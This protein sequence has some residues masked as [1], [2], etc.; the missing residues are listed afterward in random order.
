MLSQ[1]LRYIS[2][3]LL[4]NFA[5]DCVLPIILIIRV[6]RKVCFYC[7]KRNTTCFVSWMS[8]ILWDPKVK[9]KL[10][11]TTTTPAEVDSPQEETSLRTLKSLGCYIDPSGSL[12]AQGKILFK[13]QIPIE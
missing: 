10:F 9:A 7:L 2:W 8:L 5:K 4:M 3:T 1:R 13:K 12:A 11:S 6:I